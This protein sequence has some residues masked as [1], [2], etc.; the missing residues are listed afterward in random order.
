MTLV[1]H[2][3]QEGT[4]HDCQHDLYHGKQL[5]NLKYSHLWRTVKSS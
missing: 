5:S 1:C 4:A 3:S 2:T